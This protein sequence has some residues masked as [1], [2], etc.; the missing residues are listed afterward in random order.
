[1]CVPFFIFFILI[2]FIVENGLLLAWYLNRTLILPKAILGESFG[3]NRFNKLQQHHI[4]RETNQ[5]IKKTKCPKRFA[6]VSFDQLVDLSWA[7]Q[8]VRIIDRE[9]SD[10]GW[11]QRR[12]GIET[13]DNIHSEVGT[14]VNGDILFFKGKNNPYLPKENLRHSFIYQ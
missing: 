2:I 5:C 7:R 14:F 12:F 9:Q 13:K 11:L 3:W 8:H 1:M 6:L 10:L 4:L